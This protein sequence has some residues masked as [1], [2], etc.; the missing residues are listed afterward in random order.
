MD[1]TGLD[2]S[3]KLTRAKL[4]KRSRDA[5][6]SKEKSG[7][8]SP[9]EFRRSWYVEGHIRFGVSSSVLMQRYQSRIRQRYSPCEG[10]LSLKG[11]VA[12]KL[13]QESPTVM[14]YRE[15]QLLGDEGLCSGGTKLNS[16]FITIEV[17]FIKLNQPT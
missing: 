12:D 16:I 4:N 10:P 1:K 2:A 6:L 14:S 17:T 3:A 7:P 8:E 15:S 5:D 11:H 9:L 13:Y